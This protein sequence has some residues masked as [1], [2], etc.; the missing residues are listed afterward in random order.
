ML[1][2][3][4]FCAALIIVAAVNGSFA[5]NISPASLQKLEA[6]EDS[7]REL[8]KDLIVDSLTADRMRSDSLFIRTFVRTLQTPGSFYYPFENVEGI[9]VKY[10]P[11]SS[12]RIFT[13]NLVFNTYY[14]RQRGAIQLPGKNGELKLFPLRDVSEFTAAPQDSVRDANHWIGA[15]YYN[16]IET[17][18]Q[19]KKYYTLFGID[20]NNA[21]SSKKWI[22][23]LSFN[24][25]QQPVFGGPFFVYSK[26]SVKKAPQYRYEMEFKKDARI[27]LNY[28]PD[29]EMILVDHLI[30]ES[31]EPENPWTFIP[32]GDY[33]GF[34]W[35]NGKWLHVDKV[36]TE[37]LKDGE[38]PMPDPIHGDDG[39][40]S[41][42]SPWDN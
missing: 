8:A 19:D 17:S 42:K 37:K 1:V 33:E 30:S 12:F 40:S 29:L 28:V 3:K 18:Y 26:D 5:Q 24:S 36:F 25:K 9:S 10:P 13:W 27:L 32:D 41:N 35:T 34:K 31:E 20:Y 15:V 16:I 23:V 6:G 11:D 39:K 22:E 14:S 7:L 21:M 38:F 4:I 2:K